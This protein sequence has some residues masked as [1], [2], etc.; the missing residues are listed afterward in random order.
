MATGL[1][2]WNL[3]FFR[4]YDNNICLGLGS[5][6]NLFLDLAV[7]F[8]PIIIIVTTYILIHLYDQHYRI[9][10][11]IWKPFKWLLGRFYKKLYIKSSLINSITTFMFLAN[12]KV[13]SVCFDALTPVRVYEIHK[14]EVVTT[15]SRLYYDPT[16]YYFS[17]EHRPYA[18][19][20]LTILFF[21]YIFPLIF[22]FRFFHC[23]QIL[24]SYFP[25]R[26]QISFNTFMD[27]FYGCYKDGTEAGSRNCKWFA[28]V[29]PITR[30]IIGA[31]YSITLSSSF[32]SLA[33]IT[34]TLV[35]ISIIVFDPYKSQFK[36]LSISMS[37]FILFVGVFYVGCATI[38]LAA[39]S[40]SN[41][42]IDVLYISVF[43]VLC[44]SLLCVATVVLST[45]FST[46]R[47]KV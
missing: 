10:V 27:S 19:A 36:H 23:F 22:L 16:I 32:Y 17:S 13:L 46:C 8:Y 39:E 37:I 9:L 30:G 6:A 15:S 3:D 24:A 21:M 38:D 26:L 28:I 14:S 45:L 44:L 29:W 40:L 34:I 12:I 33:A 11:L 47:N 43:T 18:I 20:A 35:V 1:G 42:S 7:A 25:H 2:I 31:I 41:T 5:L 4:V